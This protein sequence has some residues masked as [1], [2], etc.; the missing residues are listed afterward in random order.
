VNVIDP[1]AFDPLE[2]MINDID[3][4]YRQGAIT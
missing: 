2:T 4:L 1:P 3:Q